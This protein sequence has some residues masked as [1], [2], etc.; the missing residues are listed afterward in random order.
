[1]DSLGTTTLNV[2]YDS[3]TP[4]DIEL[5][6]PYFIVSVFTILVPICFLY[7]NITFINYNETTEHPSRAN[8]MNSSV[9]ERNEVKIMNPQV[10]LAMIAT[11]CCFTFF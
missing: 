4:D 3:I 8:G 7:L 2:T 6:Y 5:I 10:Q 11:T 1:M 9:N